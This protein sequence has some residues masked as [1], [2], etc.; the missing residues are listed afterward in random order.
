MLFYF[1]MDHTHTCVHG[2]KFA[3]KRRAWLVEEW[4]TI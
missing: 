4:I 1:L 2:F 3:N